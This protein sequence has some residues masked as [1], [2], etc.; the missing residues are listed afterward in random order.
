M[1][2]N[3]IEILRLQRKEV[4]L[5]LADKKENRAR[6]LTILMDIDDELEEIRKFEVVKASNGGT[7]DDYNLEWK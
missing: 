3:R 1:V 6:L 5:N 4:F 7:E 2:M